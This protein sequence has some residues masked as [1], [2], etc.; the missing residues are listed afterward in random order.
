MGRYAAPAATGSA[1]ST[2]GS[3]RHAVILAGGSGTRLWPLSRASRP[4]Q[5][6]S[7]VGGRSLLRLA[8]ERVAALVPPENI[9]V[10]TGVD[11][12][13]AVLEHLPELPRDN[14]LGEPVGRDTAHAIGLAA[15]VLGARD[16]EATLA[17][18]TSDHVIEPQETFAAGL[19]TAFGMVDQ[20]PATLVTF[21]IVPTAP[22]TGLGYV[23]RGEPW[24]DTGDAV[25]SVREFRE[26]PDLATAERYLADGQ[27]LWNS[28]MFVWRADTVLRALARHLPASYD[29]LRRIAAAWDT[30]ERDQ[31]LGEVYPDLRKISV[32]YA[33][34]E[35]TARE[36]AEAR[37]AVVP[38]DVSWLDVGSWPALASMLGLD[39]SEN[40]LD[41]VTVLV[42]ASGNIIVSDDPAHLVAAVG[43]CD[44]IVVHTHDVT[45]VCPRSAAERVKELVT[46]V[47]DTHGARYA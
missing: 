9:W 25:F 33:I 11:H 34:L 1:P 46:R 24:P 5:L 18:L 30:P 6:L 41:G 2:L 45:M 10:C 47:Q 38:L 22:H 42:D 27:H 17:F 19:E 13:D 23:Q 12:R 40:A 39:A 35:P 44:T 31:V 4:K 28:G 20:N 37:I 3:M 21:G 29:G 32:D 43:L 26:K 14:V 7:V 16:P 36:Q 8:Y 15:A